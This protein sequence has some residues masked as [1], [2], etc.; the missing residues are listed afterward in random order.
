M[1]ICIMPDEILLVVPTN[2][3]L[4]AVM[5]VMYL[6]MCNTFSNY[7]NIRKLLVY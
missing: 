6:Y 1:H 4:D 7:S 2:D 3:M 5:Y